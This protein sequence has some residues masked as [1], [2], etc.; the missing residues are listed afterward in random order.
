MIIVNVNKTSP[1]YVPRESAASEWLIAEWRLKRYGDYLVAV[2]HNVVVGVYKIDGWTR[3]AGPKSGVVFELAETDLAPGGVAVGDPS[4]D[5][6]LAGQR[7]PVKYLATE[8]WVAR[9]AE[10]QA[11]SLA[12][13]L[14]PG[15][16]VTLDGD[17]VVT[18][19]W[20]ADRLASQV[21]VGADS[22]KVVLRARAA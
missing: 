1:G 5:P 4:P 10:R 7:W 14:V 21:E 17:G 8:A 12:D 6:W 19:A 3:V 13:V 15:L 16:S 18:L 9:T 2:K 22:G 20:D 11:V